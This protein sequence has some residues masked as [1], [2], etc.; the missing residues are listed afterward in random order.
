M[1]GIGLDKG[2][3]EKAKDNWLCQKQ[4]TIW[5][6]VHLL[7]KTCAQEAAIGGG[8]GRVHVGTQAAVIWSLTCACSTG[9]SA[10]LK[11]AAKG[12]GPLTHY[13]KH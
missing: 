12:R 4:R 1:N 10:R 11:P 8:P 13:Q 7:E 6:A 5:V 9:N 2:A 3:A